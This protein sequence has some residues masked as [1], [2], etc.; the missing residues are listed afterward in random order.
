MIKISSLWIALFICTYFHFAKRDASSE[1]PV[2]R[3]SDSELV[4]LSEEAARICVEI[5]Q[6][7]VEIGW[8]EP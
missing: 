3:A 2:V 5:H 1:T 6:E 4:G 7:S 8:N